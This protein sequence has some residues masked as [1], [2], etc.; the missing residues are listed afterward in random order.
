MGILSPIIL[1]PLLVLPFF[2]YKS[3]ALFQN[4]QA[5]RKTGLP[6]VLSPVHELEFWS[7]I[8]GGILRWRYDSYLLQDKG[9]PKWARFMIKDW[10]YED[11]GRAHKEFGDV[12]LVVAPGGIIC[13]IA[14]AKVAMDVCT[15][16]KDF[17]KQRE[18]MSMLRFVLRKFK[19][20]NISSEMLEPFGPNVVTAEGS[21][22][23]FH[24]RHTLPPFG[25]AVNK[26][27]WREAIRQTE[28]L[29]SSWAAQGSGDLKKDVYLLGL[30]VIACAGFGRQLDW[31]DDSKKI[32][33][34]HKMILI[35]SI[36]GVVL[37]LPQILLLPKWA[38]KHSPWKLAYDAY[39][40]FEK[41]MRE[42]I[43]VEKEKLAN[44]SEYE[45]NMRGNLLTSVLKT[46]TT[47]EERSLDSKLDRSVLN[48]D[49]VLGNIFMFLMAGKI[50]PLADCL[51]H[52]LWQRIRREK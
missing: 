12:F 4:I 24:I 40:D 36:L 50:I 17:I 20:A 18:K 44:N 29:S 26:L 5:A 37:N 7:Y 41:Y 38:L 27:V 16:R 39:V 10:G 51:M 8:V 9:W 1:F 42:F 22:W 43:Q 32:P 6:Y 30:N 47:T 11:K 21:L 49:E 34:G 45:G 48:D 31:S 33:E 35:E 3:L 14:D 23:K 46:N 15:R 2:V 19:L 13:Y 25:D 52:T 28:F